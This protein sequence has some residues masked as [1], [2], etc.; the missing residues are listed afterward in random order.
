MTEWPAVRRK[1]S[2]ETLTPGLF[3]AN[4]LSKNLYFRRDSEAIYVT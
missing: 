1:L 4:A 2:E 3:D